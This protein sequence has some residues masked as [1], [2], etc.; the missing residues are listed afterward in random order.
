[1]LWCCHV[2]TFMLFF[3]KYLSFEFFPSL[4][5]YAKYPILENSYLSMKHENF[6]LLLF[7]DSYRI[8]SSMQYFQHSP[9]M[10]TYLRQPDNCMSLL[11]NLLCS[12]VPSLLPSLV[13][14]TWSDLP[15]SHAPQPFSWIFL[16]DLMQPCISFIFFT[17]LVVPPSRYFLVST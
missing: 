1:M 3:I 16:V 12:I 6:S 17:I 14:V 9:S 15:S 11:L 7:L 10:H 2:A 8:F 4:S 5:N 13:L